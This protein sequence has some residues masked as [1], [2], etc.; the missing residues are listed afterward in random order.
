M[1]QEIN[2]WLIKVKYVLS[3]WLIKYGLDTEIE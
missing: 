1:C 2:N 3:S